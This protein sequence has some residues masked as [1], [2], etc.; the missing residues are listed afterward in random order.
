MGRIIELLRDPHRNIQEL[1]PWY[2][3]GRLDPAEHA[4]VK[5]HLDAC[6]HCQTE[7]AFDRRVN[8]AIG[9]VPV[10]VERSWAAMQLRLQSHRPKPAPTER[11]RGWLGLGLGGEGWR[12]RSPTLG[13]ALAAQAGLL[14]LTGALLLQFSPAPRY[15]VLG[16]APAGVAGNLVVIFNPDVSERAI[17]TILRANG[18]RVVDGPTSADAYVLQVPAA[19][20]E[21]A[22]GRLRKSA[23]VVLAEPIDASAGP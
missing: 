11:L 14:V 8:L 22:L 3:T 21:A 1:L 4:E 17:R 15:R 10:D 12:L 18:A 13:W 2:V 16:A 5:A 6:E 9:D 23:D 20:R 7:L 19:G